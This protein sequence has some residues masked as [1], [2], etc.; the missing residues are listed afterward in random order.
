MES[1]RCSAAIMQVVVADDASSAAILN[2]FELE[3]PFAVKLAR[4]G[5]SFLDRRELQKVV[6]AFTRAYEQ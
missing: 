3:A 4:I 5:N 1:V 2:A 6:L